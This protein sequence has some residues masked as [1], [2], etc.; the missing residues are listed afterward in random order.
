MDT[1][2]LLTTKEAA[3]LL[4]IHPETL[5]RL[6]RQG[7]VPVIKVLGVYRFHKGDLMAWLAAHTTTKPV[8]RS[9]EKKHPTLLPTPSHPLSSSRRGDAAEFNAVVGQDPPRQARR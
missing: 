8:G 3:R 6:A 2:E 1:L 5:S 4:R 9:D 7:K